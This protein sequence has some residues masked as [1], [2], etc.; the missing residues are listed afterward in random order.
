MILINLNDHFFCVCVRL[1]VCEKMILPKTLFLVALTSCRLATAQTGDEIAFDFFDYSTYMSLN[2]A[3]LNGGKGF[4]SNWVV[5]ADDSDCSIRAFNGNPN[6]VALGNSSMI[7]NNNNNGNDPCAI[8]RRIADTD[9]GDNSTPVERFVSVVFQRGT[10]DSLFSVFIGE[11]VDQFRNIERNAETIK[12][13]AGAEPYVGMH[14]FISGG[15]LKTTLS[16]NRNNMQ[17]TEV[18]LTDQNA[19]PV[20]V[21]RFVLQPHQSSAQV[22]H[23][24]FMVPPS[25]SVQL[26]IS[27]LSS[28]GVA[29]QFNTRWGIAIGTG[30]CF[31]AQVRIGTTFA[32]VMK[33]TTMSTSSTTMTRPTSVPPTPPPPTPVTTPSPPTPPTTQSPPTPTTSSTQTRTTTAVFTSSTLIA[34]T[35]V[36]AVDN[37]TNSTSS[38]A[39]D[40]MVDEGSLPIATIAGAAV[41]GGAV[42]L[43]LIALIVFLVLRARSRQKTEARSSTAPVA[44]GDAHGATEMAMARESKASMS[45]DS[46]YGDLRLASEYSAVGLPDAGGHYAPMEMTN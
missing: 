46:T 31:V 3:N 26:N 14:G 41:S 25:G 11:R 15:S 40:K 20:L 29:V 35:S 22:S 1:F 28:P 33:N 39:A 36:G 43:L 30:N 5:Q 10:G 37:T 34:S 45:T 13:G 23:N 7:G 9:L 17:R 12:V 44:A 27:S 32:S 16:V 24:F 18:S 8:V 19:S 38:N 42:L 2:D 6:L 4:L 21:V